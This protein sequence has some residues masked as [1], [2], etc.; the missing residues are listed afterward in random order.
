MAGL[1]RING[2]RLAP[3]VLAAGAAG[4]AIASQAQANLTISL[5]LAGSTPT[6]PITSAP[7]VGTTPIEIDV[8]AQV[9]AT[10]ASSYY[11]GANGLADYGFSSAYY[12]IVSTQVSPSGDVATSGGITSAALESWDKGLGAEP[13]IIGDT[14]SDGAADVGESPESTTGANVAFANG[15]SSPPAMTGVQIAST[16]PTDVV[17]LPGGGYEYLLERVYFTP[18]A[19]DASTLNRKI[20]YSPM[21]PLSSTHGGPAIWLEDGDNAE[22]GRLSST[23]GNLAQTS[24]FI[25]GSSVLFYLVPEPTSVSLLG[26]TAVGLL[27]RRRKA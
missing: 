25:Q 11:S 18:S 14:N 19:T 17:A 10:Y 24:N 22:Y 27:S 12:G 1:N 26:L 13:G 23:Q 2:R 16:N 8:W 5:Q 4:L 9:T 7:I 6:A 3:L 15:N 21:L 20:T